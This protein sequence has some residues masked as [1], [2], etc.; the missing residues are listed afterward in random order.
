M[1]W[2]IHAWTPLWSVVTTLFRLGRS[3][4]AALVL[5]G[6][7][8]SSS[9][10]FPNQTVPPELEALAKHEGEPRLVAL[11]ALGAT[12]SLP[13]LIRIVRRERSLPTT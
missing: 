10:P 8:A 5:G 3:E 6:C 7:Q 13:E 9:S 2:T 12:M 1:G 4:E 11:L